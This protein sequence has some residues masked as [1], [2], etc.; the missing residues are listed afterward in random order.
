MLNLAQRTPDEKTRSVF[1]DSGRAPVLKE[2]SPVY[3][4]LDDSSGG[5]VLQP[6]IIAAI[7]QDRWTID[8]ETSEP[9]LEAGDE[10]LIY[11]TQIEKFVQRRVKVE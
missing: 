3:L 10:R 1:S 2:G 5:R 7:A 6:G 11:F 8:L 4:G 9:L